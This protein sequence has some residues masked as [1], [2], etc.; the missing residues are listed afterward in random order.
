MLNVAKIAKNENFYTLLEYL[1]IVTSSHH[2]GQGGRKE[3]DK[4]QEINAANDQKRFYQIIIMMI[5]KV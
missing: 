4:K 1:N 3:V 5:T 2:N